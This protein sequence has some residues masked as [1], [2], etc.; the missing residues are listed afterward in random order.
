MNIDIDYL[1]KIIEF[2][3]MRILTQKVILIWKDIERF[4]M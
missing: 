1:D 3:F 4:G 2:R